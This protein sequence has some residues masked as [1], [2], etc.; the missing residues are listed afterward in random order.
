[1]KI[2]TVSGQH[3]TGFFESSTVGGTPPEVILLLVLQNTGASPACRIQ[4]VVDR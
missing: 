2:T 4:G 3:N 1:M